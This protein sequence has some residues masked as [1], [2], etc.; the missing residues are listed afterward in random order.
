MDQ[1]KVH[2]LRSF[3]NVNANIFLIDE[4]RIKISLNET[5]LKATQ[6]NKI[7][8]VHKEIKKK[9]IRSKNKKLEGKSPPL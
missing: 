2:V 6:K 8:E 5:Q 3:K 7:D 4:V 9:P 1:M